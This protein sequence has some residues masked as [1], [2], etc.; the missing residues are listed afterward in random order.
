M[1]ERIKKFIQDLVEAD[2]KRQ[3][4][5]FASDDHRL[6]AAALMVHVISVDGTVDD[7]EKAKIRAVLQRHFQLSDAETK[8]LLDEARR[9]DLEAVDLYG[10]TSVLKRKLDEDGRL[11]IVEMMWEMVFADGVV[12][13]FEDNTVWRT[14]EL[15]GISTRDRIKLKQK[16]EQ[17]A[18]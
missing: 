3:D 1:F 14:A 2:E 17:S 4:A 18:G 5:R 11:K 15:L 7:T 12:H 13:E 9:R 8:H 16:V 6:A 10:F